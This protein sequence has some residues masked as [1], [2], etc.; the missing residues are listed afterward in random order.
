MFD[1]TT[2]QSVLLKEDWES[3]M[4]LHLDL[5]GFNLCHFSLMDTRGSRF[6]DVVGEW[7]V[8]SVVKD[9]CT[10]V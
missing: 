7:Y 9:T 2:I 4:L 3:E 5:K 8:V 1:E 10:P 6:M